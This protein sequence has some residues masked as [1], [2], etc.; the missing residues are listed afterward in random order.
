MVS[1]LVLGVFLLLA[2]Q[3]LKS[4]K[5]DLEAKA[6]RD[7]YGSKSEAWFMAQQFVEDRL[8]SPGTAEYGQQGLWDTDERV[9]DLGGGKYRVRGW[10]DS[11]NSFGAKVRAN[12]ALT[13]QYDGNER[14]RLVEGPI[15]QQ[16]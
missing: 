10:V 1:A 12:F 2:Y 7:K 5:E 14:W 11:Q 8:K 6:R 4:P 16:R 15:I 9:T 3:S 13:I